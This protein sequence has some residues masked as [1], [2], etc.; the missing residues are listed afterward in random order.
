MHFSYF[1]RNVIHL[2]IVSFLLSLNHL[3]P[4]LSIFY[5]LY[6]LLLRLFWFDW[7]KKNG[8]KEIRFVSRRVHNFPF[9]Y[10]RLSFDQ[11][12]AKTQCNWCIWKKKNF[13]AK[14]LNSLKLKMKFAHKIQFSLLFD[15]FEFLSVHTTPSFAKLLSWMWKIHFVASF[16]QCCCWFFF[17]LFTSFVAHRCEMRLRRKTWN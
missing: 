7:A 6:L 5:R 3:S 1:I 12:R 11:I 4:F 8:R 16:I 17:L 2:F 10:V 15:F 14:R 13:V 9:D